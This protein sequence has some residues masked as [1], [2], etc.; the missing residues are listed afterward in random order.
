MFVDHLQLADFRSYEAVDVAA[1]RRGHDVRRRQ[2]A[3]QDQS[4]RGG[5]IPVDPRARTGSAPRCRWSGSERSG[6]WSGP[7]CRPGST[8][9]ASC[10]SRSR[11]RPAG[12]TG[13]GSTGRRSGGR[14]SCSVC[15]APSSSPRRTWPSSRATRRDRRRFLDELLTARWPRLAGV[16]ADYDRVLRQRNT[17]LKSL[18]GRARGGPPPAE[19]AAHPRRLGHPPRRAPAANCSTPGCRPWPTSLPHVAKAYADIAPTNSDATAEYKTRSMAAGRRSTAPRGAD[20]GLLVA[21]MRERRTEEIARGDLAGRAAPRRHLPVASVRCPPRGTP[22]TA[23]PGRWPWPCGWAASTCC[24]PT[25]SNRCWCWTTCSPSWT[26]IR[27]ERLA[28][29]V[30][31]AEQVLVTAAVGADVPELLPAG[32]IAVAGGAVAPDD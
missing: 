10:S 26:P 31:A 1:G 17:L 7:G 11:S 28:Q 32:G 4:G 8:T 24:A 21:A 13:P 18:S 15:C 27:R 3:G 30:G 16:R 29:A 9:R 5:G 12:P 25:G 19:A 6:R 20:R 14:G 22:A 23:S 2:R